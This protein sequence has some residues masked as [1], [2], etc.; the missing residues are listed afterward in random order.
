[1]SYGYYHEAWSEHAN[2][3]RAL[4]EQNKVSRVCEVGGGANPL[5]PLDYLRARNIEYTILDVSQEE[6]DKAPS[7]YRKVVADICDSNIRGLGKF[8]LVFTKMLAEHVQD[9]G[10]FHHNV[11]GMLSPGGL[12]FHFFP[13]LFTPPLI[14]NWLLPEWITRRLLQVFVPRD[15]TKHGKFPAYSSW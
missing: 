10:A 2:T 15:Q 12:A 9:G 13:T 8:D 6:L 1:V 5:L 3:L 7:D 4:I 14:F 11:Y